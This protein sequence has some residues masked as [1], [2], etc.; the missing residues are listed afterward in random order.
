MASHPF[1]HRRRYGPVDG[2]DRGC[3]GLRKSRG[4][5]SE[6]FLTG[7]VHVVLVVALALLYLIGTGPFGGYLLTA[8][9]ASGFLSYLDWWRLWASS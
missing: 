6:F 5:E 2:N 4:F 8:G 1:G 7:A 3:P 9:D